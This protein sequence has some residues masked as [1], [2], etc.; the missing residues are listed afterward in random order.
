V[1]ATLFTLPL[2]VIAF[3]VSTALGVAFVPYQLWLA[4]ATSLAFGYA[5]Q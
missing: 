4:I 3:R 5:S 2:L 1:L